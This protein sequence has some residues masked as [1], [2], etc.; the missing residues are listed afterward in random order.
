MLAT[1]GDVFVSPCVLPIYG[2]LIWPNGIKTKR[3]WW[4]LYPFFSSVPL[5]HTKDRSNVAKVRESSFRNGVQRFV[6]WHGLVVLFPVGNASGIHTSS[7]SA[8]NR[9]LTVTLQANSLEL[10]VRC[11]V[12]VQHNV[13]SRVGVGTVPQ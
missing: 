1:D 8:V 5:V 12:R 9:Q 11:I 10:L 2:A 13:T 3:C 7:A 4:D 6:H